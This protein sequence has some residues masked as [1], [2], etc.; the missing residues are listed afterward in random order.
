MTLLW[1]R[2]LGLFFEQPI[3]VGATTRADYAVFFSNQGDCV[4]IF[5]PGKTIPSA[6]YDAKG[7]RT[8]TST[9]GGTSTAAAF[10][11]GGW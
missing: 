7:S 9:S 2:A 4:D 1:N 6:V 11:G 8:A 5:A 10:V 3:T